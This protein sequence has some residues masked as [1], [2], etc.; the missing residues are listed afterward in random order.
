MGGSLTDYHDNR[1]DS[2]VSLP[3]EFQFAPKHVRYFK[4]FHS[5]FR[6]AHCCLCRHRSALDSEKNASE[7]NSNWSPANAVPKLSK[8]LEVTVH[9]AFEEH[10]ISQSDGYPAS[11]VQLADKPDELSVDSEEECREGKTRREDS[12]NV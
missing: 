2:D 9:T 4:F 3:D 8:R 12:V 11:N 6:Q 7:P 5:S 10:Q 1:R